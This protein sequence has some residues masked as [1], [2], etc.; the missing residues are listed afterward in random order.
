MKLQPGSN[1]GTVPPEQA[2]KAARRIPW[3]LQA[4]SAVASD[5]MCRPPAWRLTCYTPHGRWLSTQGDRPMMQHGGNLLAG[6]VSMEEARLMAYQRG[7]P[8]EGM[9]VFP[10]GAGTDLGPMRAAADRYEGTLER[11]RARVVEELVRL[12]GDVAGATTAGPGPVVVAMAR[13]G[14][15]TGAP[16]ASHG[17]AA[18]GG[19]PTSL[20]AAD[21]TATIA[22]IRSKGGF[23][24]E[25]ED[26]EEEDIVDDGAGSSESK[27]DAGDGTA[28]PT[29]AAGASTAAGPS[30]GQEHSTEGIDPADGRLYGRTHATAREW[31]ELVLK[32]R[33][34]RVRT[35]PEVAPEAPVLDPRFGQRLVQ[36]LQRARS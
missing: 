1:L 19:R 16:G 32:D 5:S 9:R 3:E 29:D 18:A 27:S 14:E 2:A 7:A 20:T 6:D 21:A 33:S 15:P 30:A 12:G 28:D 4:S 24:D 10:M 36:A 13:G 17:G 11:Q 35:I 34:I 26:D 8:L 25:E 23:E 31:L 22:A